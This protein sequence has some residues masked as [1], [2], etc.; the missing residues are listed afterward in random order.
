MKIGFLEASEAQQSSSVHQLGASRH[1]DNWL[2]LRNYMIEVTAMPSTSQANE[3]QIILLSNGYGL[4]IIGSRGE[5]SKRKTLRTSYHNQSPSTITRF[6][7]VGELEH[8]TPKSPVHLHDSAQQGRWA[9][10]PQNRSAW[11][12]RPLNLSKARTIW[13]GYI[14]SAT[15]TASQQITLSTIGSITAGSALCHFKQ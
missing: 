2:T 1:A 14:A 9:M 13:R 8:A 7:M 5:N 10:A 15:V 11:P 4:F 3:H 6:T 12:R